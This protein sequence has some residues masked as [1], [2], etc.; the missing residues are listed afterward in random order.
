MIDPKHLKF[1]TLSLHAGQHPDP[2]TGARAR[3]LI[4]RLCRARL[5]GFDA[6]IQRDSWKLWA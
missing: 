4:L 5:S 1:S 2:A 6:S 3:V